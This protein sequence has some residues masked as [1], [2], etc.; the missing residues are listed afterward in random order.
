MRGVYDAVEISCIFALGRRG[1]DISCF[2]FLHERGHCYG[3]CVRGRARDSVLKCS[4]KMVAVYVAQGP[5]SSKRHSGR[6][7]GIALRSGE[8]YIPFGVGYIRA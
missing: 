2:T 8:I 4:W 3:S 6:Y 5:A 1:G 7:S